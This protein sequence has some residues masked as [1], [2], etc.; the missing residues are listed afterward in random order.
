[1]STKI[2]RLLLK[3][4]KTYKICALEDI[5]YEND[6]L[7]AAAQKLKDGAEIV[8]FDGSSIADKD[9]LSVGKKLRGLCGVFNA[10][11][12]IRGRIDIAKL[13]GADGV[14]FD[15]TSIGISEG[16]ELTENQLLL[17][18]FAQSGILPEENLID[19]CDFI[20]SQAPISADIKTFQPN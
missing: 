5:S 20:V 9:Y 19:K 10:L 4:K 3:D 13:T 14:I 7:N 8:E 11:L 6:F 17:G 2:N 1:M 18:Y 15:D 16:F 12:I